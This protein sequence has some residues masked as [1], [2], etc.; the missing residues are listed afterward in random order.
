MTDDQEQLMALMTCGCKV[1]FLH[2]NY[3]PEDEWKFA[4]DSAYQC[5]NHPNKQVKVASV[6]PPE[7]EDLFDDRQWLRDEIKRLEQ[8]V[9]SLKA[10]TQRLK[11]RGIEDMKHEIK[12]LRNTLRWVVETLGDALE[13]PQSPDLVSLA[14]TIRVCDAPLHQSEEGTL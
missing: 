8:D 4:V 5:E 10:E 14:L 13:D 3:L 1:P 7:D 9:D 2:D 12:E 6:W 11:N